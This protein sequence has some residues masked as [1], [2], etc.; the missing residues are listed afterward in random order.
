MSNKRAFT[1]IEII[2]SA[3]IIVL[4]MSTAFYAYY[5]AR[6]T[7]AG[8]EAMEQYYQL[9]SKL[10]MNLKRDL[11]GAISLK[12]T[13]HGR[14]ELEVMTLMPEGGVFNKKIVY[15]KSADNKIIERITEG[16]VEKYDFTKLIKDDEFVFNI[17]R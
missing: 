4:V 17:H 11:R 12:E 6:S 3:V 7:N 15:I 10:E 1:M 5:N 8:L 2:S 14:Y 9:C 13:Q 16:K